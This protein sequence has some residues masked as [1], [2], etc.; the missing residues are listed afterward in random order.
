MDAPK[1]ERS[2]H[3]AG[4]PIGLTA[5]GPIRVPPIVGA[6]RCRSA[7]L[8]KRASHAKAVDGG[9]ARRATARRRPGCFDCSARDE[10]VRDLTFHPGA[11]AGVGVISHRFQAHPHHVALLLPAG[12]LGSSRAHQPPIADEDLGQ[13]PG[14]VRHR[15]GGRNLRRANR[16]SRAHRAGEMNRWLRPQRRRPSLAPAFS[17]RSSSSVR[18]SP[19]PGPVSR[20]PRCQSAGVPPPRMPME[21]PSPTWLATGSTWGPRSRRVQARPSTRCPRRPRH[22]RPERRSPRP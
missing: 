8:V 3:W 11:P 7:C 5:R 14:P 15:H 13:C 9:H 17:S 18:W 2:F 4:A 16:A 21:R 10:I 12:H 1:F 19:P 22:R 20:R 6:V